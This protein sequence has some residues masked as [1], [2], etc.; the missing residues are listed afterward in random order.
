[1]ETEGAFQF[2][3]FLPFFHGVSW[4][5]DFPVFHFST[6]IINMRW[7]GKCG[8]NGSGDGNYEL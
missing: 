4:K 2:S 8:K 7:N 3:L 5:I 1:M 6:R